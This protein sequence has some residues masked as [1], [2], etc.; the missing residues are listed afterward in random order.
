MAT[1]LPLPDLDDRRWQDLVDE[2]RALIP[3][4]APQW[5]DHNVHDPGITLMELFAWVAE[6]DLYTVNQITDAHRRKLLALAGITPA[7][8]RPSRT[9]L[10]VRLAPGAPARSLPAGLEFE[11]RDPFGEP[12]RF[13]SLHE[14]TVQPGRLAAVRTGRDA[15]LEDLTTAWRRGEPVH[16]FGPDPHPGSALYLGFDLPSP[17]PAG[18]VISLGVAPAAPGDG[19]PPASRL[20]HHS[21][22]LAWELLTGPGQWTRLTP[23][24]PGTNLDPHTDP[25][26]GTNLDPHTDPHAGT[27]PDPHTVPHAEGEAGDGVQSGAVPGGPAGAADGGFGGSGGFGGPGGEAEARLRPGRVDDRTRSLTVEGRVLLALPAPAAAHAPA[28]RDDSLAWVRARLTGGAY[29]AAPLLAGLAFN[30]VQV[31]QAVPAVSRLRIA[32]DAP[33]TGTPPAPG[34]RVSLDLQVT[35]RGEIS[36]LAFAPPAADR[37]AVRVLAYDEA[38]R[39]LTIEAAAVRRGTGG[40]LQRVEITGAPVVA[41]SLRMSS[42]EDGTWRRWTWRPDFDASNR[43]DAHAVLDATAGTVALGD[44]ERGRVAPAGATLLVTGD[45]TRAAAGDLPVGAVD[46]VADSP[47]NRAVVAD[48]PVLAGQLAAVANVVPAAGGRGAETVDAATARAQDGR[49]RATR[50]V[51][52]DDHVKLAM[53]TPGVRLARAEARA[54]AHPGFPCL[55]T[56]GVVTVLIVPHLPARRP[57]PSPG[58]RRAVA[59]HLD[60]GRVLGTRIEVIGPE[61]VTVTVRATVAAEAGAR[62][63]DLP[64]AVRGAL[65]RFLHP[66]TGGPDATGW[67]FGRDVY[68]SEVLGVIGE[69]PGVAHVLA[70]ELVAD[71]GA[72][73]C[74]D[75][76]LCPTGLVDSGPHEIDVR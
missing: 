11:G 67:P 4:Y 58:L 50:A 49:E 60:R 9:L 40:P 68:R 1:A 23:V 54:N 53:R 56:P 14:V 42:L 32:P 48:L 8:P 66:I 47:H 28:G 21:A 75:L 22:R 71:G 63:G 73:S 65:D 19:P 7:P 57:A 15:P 5:T 6:M 43:P 72:P 38:G 31:V 70:L 44:G 45:L 13:R 10:D 41:A 35:R 18:T 26:A 30:A 46:R 25:H 55:T 29:D 2:G 52:L 17:W 74:A 12:V 64:A 76:R 39:T 36:R 37:P 51:T 34:E 59:C 61:Y 16:P 33:V 62:P 24:H 69:V 3:F 20:P 27:D